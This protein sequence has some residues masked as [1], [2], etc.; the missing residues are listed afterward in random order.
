LIDA[1]RGWKRVTMAK[2]T[3]TAIGLMSG[4]SMDGIDVAVIDTDGERVLA[5]GPWS[6]HP[7]PAQLRAEVAA[8]AADPKRAETD[9]LPA[10]EAKLTRANGDAVEALIGANR[11]DRARV[12]VV[13]YHGQTV[14]HRPERRWTR[15]L[16]DGAALSERLG[17]PVVNDFRSADLAAGGEGAP[18]APLYHKALAAGLEQ[19]L[20]VLNLGGV[21]N[22]TF[23][24]G[25]TVI[26]FDTG[27]ANAMIDDWALSHTGT[28][29]DVDGKL[30]R[31]GRID[32][33]ALARLMDNP[34]FERRPPKS[35]DRNDFSAAPVAGLGVADGAATL[36]AF[37]AESVKRS[38]KLLPKAPTR[39]LVT[40]G[41]RHN[42]VLMA[43]LATRLG[44]PVE[45]VEKAGWQGD[46]L[47]AQ[48]FAFLAVRSLLG[49]PLSVPG[50]TG[51]PKPITGG[52][53]HRPARSA[54]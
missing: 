39:W 28:A 4:T 49:L 34:Y 32:E 54:A 10:L 6:T 23:L 36:T 22:V 48:A 24:D 51:V 9:P 29:C 46:A 37:T 15:Q 52:R 38:L 25:E 50:T 14:L 33:A 16:G 8:V 41:G 53:L 18:L 45:P 31:A 1:D 12:A 35:L 20:A 11:I 2:Q 44:V 17:I 43:M 42:P 19:P 13:G 3:M 47:E 30:A 27:P 21:G 26:A 5:T 7:Y 40:G